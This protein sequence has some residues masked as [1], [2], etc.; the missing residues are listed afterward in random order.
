MYIKIT[1]QKNSTDQLFSI[2]IHNLN[3]NLNYQRK[4]TFYHSVNNS[5]FGFLWF[6]K[7]PHFS[8]TDPNPSA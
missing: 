7:G 2:H 1:I 8:A 3:H 5:F 4:L 6:D